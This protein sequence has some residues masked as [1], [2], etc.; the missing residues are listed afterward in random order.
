[1]LDNLLQPFAAFLGSLLRKSPLTFF[2]KSLAL[3]IFIFAVLWAIQ[4]ATGVFDPQIH[5]V[6]QQMYADTTR[7]KLTKLHFNSTGKL[8]D[9]W[10]E[11]SD[12]RASHPTMKEIADNIDIALSSVQ[13]YA[14]KLFDSDD[15][16]HIW[17][18]QH[19]ARLHIVKFDLSNEVNHIFIAHEMLLKAIA[20][21]K[22]QSHSTEKFIDWASDNEIQQNLARDEM[23]ILALKYQITNNETELVR[24][25]SILRT[26]FNGC[27]SDKLENAYVLHLQTLQ[28]LG[29]INTA[30]TT[31]STP[32]NAS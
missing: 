14:Y 7:K 16:F 27:H 20:I 13:G 1:M 23:Q 31:Q 9:S 5:T 21:Y 26:S 28:A 4:T 22:S 6:G 2:Y 12:K 11:N 30:N 3:F 19:L 18:L 8:W 17:Y 10:V 32:N 15:D 25:K 29:C 24:A